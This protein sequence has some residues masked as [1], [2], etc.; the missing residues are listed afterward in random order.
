MNPNKETYQ[1]DAGRVPDVGRFAVLKPDVASRLEF[2]HQSADRRL[3][4]RDRNVYTK[5][6]REERARKDSEAV[7]GMW[8]P[9]S[10]TP[11]RSPL[12]WGVVWPLA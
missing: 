2:H 3:V 12:G 8:C 10:Q 4:E 11:W 1:V 5:A 6:S 9:A 7:L